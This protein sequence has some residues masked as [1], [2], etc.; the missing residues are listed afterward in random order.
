M[1]SIENFFSERRQSIFP[2]APV[3]VKGSQAVVIRC[4][5]CRDVHFHGR[6]D[7]DPTE[8]GATLGMRLSHCLVGE[9]RCYD[10]TIAPAG[11]VIPRRLRVRYDR[12]GRM[13]L[14]PRTPER[15]DAA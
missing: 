2:D 1:S 9:R 3:V 14:V 15:T 8:S 13:R 12:Y 11:T 4:P 5:F 6:Y 10:L 7:D